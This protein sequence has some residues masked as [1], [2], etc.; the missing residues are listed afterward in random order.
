[1]DFIH[2]KIKSLYFKFLF[3]SMAS[4]VVM[5]IYS[6]VDTIAVGQSEG[7]VGAAAMAV[8]AP[9]Y[10]AVVFL[11]VLCGVGGSV[12]MSIERGRGDAQ[13]GNEWFTV[14]VVAMSLLTVLVWIVFAA[15]K[16][17]IFV[18]FG[19]SEEILPKT[20]EYGNWIARFLPIFIFPIFI[21]AFVRNDGS[22]RLAMAA[23]VTG[24]AV[25][26]AGDWFL[27][28]PMKMGMTGAALATVAGT[29]VQSV[30]M[31]THFFRRSCALSLK[32]PC[33]VFKGISRVLAVGAGAGVLE[34]GTVV[35]GILMNNQIR[36]YGT[37]SHL[38]VYGVV[39]T[40]MA[41]FQALFG[42]V[43]QAIQPLVSSNFGAGEHGRIRRV[44]HLSLL[45][46][47]V[48]GAA[49]TAA[50][51][52]FPL[53]ITRI[54]MDATDDVISVAPRIFRTFFPMFIFLG[55]SVLADYYLQSVMKKRL[56]LAVGL[57]HS[58]AASGFA[59]FLL[60]LAFGIDG[61]WLAL[62][63]AEA[64]TAAFALLAIWRGNIR[65][66]PLTKM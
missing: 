37:T 14:S 26:M 53:E 12:L 55:V 44:W 18:L 10:G 65:S 57:L 54:F 64:V 9:V 51:E 59:I 30:I 22:P 48:M 21:G 15:A 62:P 19:A 58:V 36:A 11:S 63:V 4:A 40:I 52:A 38:A 49:F 35:I 3:P 24:G 16:E 5:S 45:T 66:S 60:P 42:G 29:A 50:G 25:N 39:A 20:L 41:L 27:V 23:V 7:A 17:P 34:L 6:F 8:I 33:R 47:L 13:K 28:F 56:S 1:M 31:A 43:G 46:V 61:V 32:K 2:D